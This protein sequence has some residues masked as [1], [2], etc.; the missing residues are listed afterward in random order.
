M[1]AVNLLPRETKRS[2]SVSAERLPLVVGVV[3]AALVMASLGGM[4]M[5]ESSKVSSAKSEL[6]IAKAQFAATPVPAADPN[7]IPTPAA[8]AAT[9]QPLFASVSTALSQRIAWDRVLREF[10]LVLPN[11]VWVTSLNL[12]APT[13]GTSA[14]GLLLQGTTYSYGGVARLLSRLSLVP[15]LTAVTLTSS[16]RAE[17]LV[18]FSISAGIKGA[19]VPAAAAP[20]VPAPTSGASS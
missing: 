12:A 6:A 7:A 4:F 16:S 14:N 13:G 2:Q 15:D 9:Q 3:V 19:P 1:R 8:V 10:S 11:D 20:V 5:L 18:T 17:N